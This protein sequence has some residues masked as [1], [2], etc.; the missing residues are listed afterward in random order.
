MFLKISLSNEITTEQSKFTNNELL[1][2]H[3]KFL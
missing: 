1:H 2:D 3:R